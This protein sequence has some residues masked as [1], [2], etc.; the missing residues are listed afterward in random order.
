MPAAE[1]AE[2]G[3]E[4]GT[5]D[6]KGLRLLSEVSPRPV[7]W[8]GTATWRWAKSRSAK[9][10]RGRTSPRCSMTWRPG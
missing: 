2:T 10:I 3:Y 4:D 9:A 7:E 5:A 6:V 1:Q 8:L